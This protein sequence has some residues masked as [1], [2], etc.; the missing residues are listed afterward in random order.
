V[1]EALNQKAGIAEPYDKK[2]RTLL[3][4]LLAGYA[5]SYL[6]SGIA[7]SRY[8]AHRSAFLSVSTLLTGR[9]GLDATQAA[10]LYDA[11]AADDA[12]FPA[13]VQELDILISQRGIEALQLQKVLDTRYPALAA[14]PRNIAMAW[15]TGIVGSGAKARCVAYETA[16][17]A[18]IVAD[19]LKPPSYCAGAYGSWTKKPTI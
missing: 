8:D 13:E 5:V 17:N 16:L 11:L 1:V 18:T 15:F 3:A 7:Q 2:R 4:G 12:R 14:L 19:V 10:R 6:P 9:T